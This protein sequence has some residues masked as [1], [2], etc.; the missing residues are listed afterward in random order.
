ME[1]YEIQ[2]L[3]QLQYNT[4]RSKVFLAKTN[5]FVYQF[6]PNLLP[7]KPPVNAAPP[8]SNPARSR[9]PGLG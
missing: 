5:I 1:I 3:W 6:H 4:N 8:M 2:M 9:L 7:S